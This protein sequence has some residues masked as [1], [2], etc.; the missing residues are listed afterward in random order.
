MVERERATMGP[1]V[2]S[3]LVPALMPLPKRDHVCGRW[4]VAHVLLP[5]N[6]LGPPIGK[7]RSLCP[8]KTVPA[9]LRTCKQCVITATYSA[10]M[11]VGLAWRNLYH[12]T[13]GRRC[14][15]REDI[16]EVGLLT[17]VDHTLGV[18]LQAGLHLPRFASLIG[19]WLGRHTCRDKD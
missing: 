9:Y 4:R 10:N 6:A 11:Q 16:V 5:A 15:I 13:G 19:V 3:A 18:D 7:A 2:R 14:N 12:R 8:G 17:I 1:A